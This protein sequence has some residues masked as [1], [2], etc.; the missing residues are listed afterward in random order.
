MQFEEKCVECKLIY[1]GALTDISL[2]RVIFVVTITQLCNTF[3]NDKKSISFIALF[4][5]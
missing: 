4:K 2:V 3:H 1:E 5:A